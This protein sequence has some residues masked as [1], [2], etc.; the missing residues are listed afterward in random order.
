MRYR[1]NDVLD[2][3]TKLTGAGPLRM[4]P[5]KAILMKRLKSIPVQCLQIS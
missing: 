1:V 2:T 5:A 3:V 4:R